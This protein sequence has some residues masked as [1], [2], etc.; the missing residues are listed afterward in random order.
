MG[1]F[2]AWRSR[3]LDFQATGFIEIMT[4]DNCRNFCL[5]SVLGPTDIYAIRGQFCGCL[6]RAEDG[7]VKADD[8]DCNLN[9]NTPDSKD[10]QTCGGNHVMSLYCNGTETDCL[11]FESKNY[12]LKELPLGDESIPDPQ[13]QSP[14]QAEI[15]P[16]LPCFNCTKYLDCFVSSFNTKLAYIPGNTP[17]ECI[18]FCSTDWEYY[19][20][21]TGQDEIRPRT[22]YANVGGTY[23][24][25]FTVPSCG[26]YDQLPSFEI[27]HPDQ[28]CKKPCPTHP[29]Q[30]CGGE[31]PFYF[32]MY[33]TTISDD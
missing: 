8:E 24:A 9:C 26:C 33:F 6:P 7:L 3:T 29:D 10:L 30:T 16:T 18:R 11:N 1:C 23:R 21:L 32:T 5:E 12:P 28:H 20:R 15:V 4:V 22:R 27:V 2:D 19:N 17:A 25:G 13:E 14:R 31:P